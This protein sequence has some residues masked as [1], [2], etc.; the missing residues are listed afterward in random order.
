MFSFKFKAIIRKYFAMLILLVG[1]LSS[2]TPDEYTYDDR[3]GSKP[4]DLSYVAI[5][6]FPEG[7]AFVSSKAFVTLPSNVLPEFFLDGWIKDGV[8]MGELTHFKI[9][10]LD[11]EI[12]LSEKND[13]KPGKYAVAVKVRTYDNIAIQAED[14]TYGLEKQLV[15]SVVFKEGLTFVVLSKLIESLTYSPNLVGAKPGKLFTSPTPVIVGTAPATFE[16]Y[17]TH[18][19]DFVIDA[20]TGVISLADGHTLAEAD[21][22]LSVKVTND[23]GSVEF[24]EVITVKV[25]PATEMVVRE[26][27]IPKYNSKN[28][29]VDEFN[30]PNMTSISVDATIP[31]Q[32]SNKRWKSAWCLWH[33]KDADGKTFH[34]AEFRPFKSLQEDYMLFT[35]KVSFVDAEK[36]KAI[37]EIGHKYGILDGFTFD[38]VVS[39]DFAGDAST[40]TWTSINVP[41]VDPQST[42]AEYNVDLSAFD[43]QEVTVGVKVKYVLPP[44]KKLTDLTKNVWI[45]SFVV[46]ATM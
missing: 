19:S 40:A 8:D 43:G 9:D 23:A 28:Y 15:D 26:L 17:G 34:F 21:Y 1:I 18:A 12:T 7:D 20:N 27:M 25:A 13:L 44:G 14:G 46:K 38:V 32:E 10:T 24:P 33:Q 42:Y 37:L 39:T 30:L 16:L 2:C 4:V 5:P 45:K 35:D 36:A 29:A 41:L 6:D 31:S 11:G 3:Y 22:K